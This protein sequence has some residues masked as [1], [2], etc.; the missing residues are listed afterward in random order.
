MDAVGATMQP[1]QEGERRMN[2]G[3]GAPWDSSA[4]VM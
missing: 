4:A 2:H 3:H 1:V